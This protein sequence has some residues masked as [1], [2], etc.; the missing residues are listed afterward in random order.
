MAEFRQDTRFLTVEAA[1]CSPCARR[2]YLVQYLDTYEYVPRFWE[3][4][5]L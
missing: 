2:E 5:L 3:M 4:G 1:E